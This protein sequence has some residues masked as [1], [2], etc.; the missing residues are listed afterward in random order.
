MV[1]EKRH[2]HLERVGHRGTV[3]VVE[4][5]V[6][7]PE[8]GVEIERRRQGIVGHAAEPVAQH[9]PGRTAVRCQRTIRLKDGVVVKDG[10]LAALSNP[11]MAAVVEPKVE[12]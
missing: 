1:V 12:T 5:V 4:H 6:D 3:E 7:K 2:A 10:D 11:R 8:L 9:P